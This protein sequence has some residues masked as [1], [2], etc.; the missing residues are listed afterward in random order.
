LALAGGAVG[1]V[2][3]HVLTSSLVAVGLDQ[4][5]RATEVRVDAITAAFGLA[6]AMAAGLIIAA[7]SIL[8]LSR[9][10]VSGAL[11]DFSRSS[12]AS[13]RVGISR[14]VLVAA[15]V[16]VAFVLLMG[17]AVLLASFREL[18]RVAPGFDTEGILTASTLAPSARY[19]GAPQL[20]SLMNR[21]I[22]EVRSIPVV[23]S[24]GATNAIPLQPIFNHN[25]I[26]PEGY[27]TRAG[28]AVVSPIQ[29][30]A[31]DGYM[32]TMGIRLSAGR[33]FDQRDTASSQ[34]VILIDKQ[35]A[36]RFWPGQD[37]VGRRMYTPS[38]RNTTQADANTRW[39]TVVGVVENA[40]MEGLASA[41]N[42][43]GVYY[44]PGSQAPLRSFTLAIKTRGEPES[45]APAVRAALGRI[46]PLLAMFDVQTM[47][48]RISS[49]LASR[50][51]AL[52]LSLAF[53]A[54]SLLL[55]SVGLYGVLSYLF[56]QRRREFAVRIA[57]GCTPGQAFRLFL[58]E[59]AILTGAGLVLGGTAA[60]AS[61]SIADK[62]AYGVKPFDPVVLGLVV[63]TLAAVAFL[64]TALPALQAARVDPAAALAEQ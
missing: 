45:V 36:G 57:V 42:E 2:F 49:S 15:Q 28:E 56:V 8:H 32:E 13:R 30:V 61:R 60:F 47:Q 48:Q 6:G 38:G 55:A 63:L 46:D 4:F 11:A 29:V 34:P 31:T 1:L 62:F 20:A 53:G 18:L 59:G 41:A 16:A 7:V 64:A 51:T 35:L 58:H 22:A 17:S 14:K 37:A 24:A 10:S 25:V 52:T 9:L 27:V 40:R 19:A 23:V 50:R 12:T 44:F 54:I 39:L 3:A 43:P 33:Y 26:V 5:P 21:Y